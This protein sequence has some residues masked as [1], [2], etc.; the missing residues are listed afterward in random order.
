MRRGIAARGG[1]RS[2][3]DWQSG[4]YLSLGFDI[5]GNTYQPVLLRL[6]LGAGRCVQPSWA[7]APGEQKAKEG[8]HGAGCATKLDSHRAVLKLGDAASTLHR[9]IE[10]TRLP[11]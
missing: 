7:C 5:G 6:L 9:K 4:Y 11:D 10:V 1:S 8:W 2:L 3:V